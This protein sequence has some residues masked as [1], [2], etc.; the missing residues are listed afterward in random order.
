MYWI[1]I[2]SPSFF[3][4]NFGKIRFST[5][6][7]ELQWTGLIWNKFMNPRLA[8]FSWHLF[9][10]KIPTK[11]WAKIEAVPWLLDAI[12]TFVAKNLTPTFSSHAIGLIPRGPSFSGLKALPLQFLSPQ[13]LHGEPFLAM[14][15]SLEENVR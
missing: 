1:L 3:K 7:Y 9:H 12:T 15:M 13:Q 6:F 5:K 8:C 10:R 14:E 11:S 4:D 2:I